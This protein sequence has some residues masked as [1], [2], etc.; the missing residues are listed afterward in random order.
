MLHGDHSLAGRPRRS[1][2]CI[3]HCD[4]ELLHARMSLTAS[5]FPSGVKR[6]SRSSYTAGSDD[7][8]PHSSG[9]STLPAEVAAADAAPAET[10]SDLHEH[11]GSRTFCRTGRLEG[12]GQEEHVT[13]G[14]HPP[15][16]S[17][18]THSCSQ[19]KGKQVFLVWGQTLASPFKRCIRADEQLCL[20]YTRTEADD[21]S[22]VMDLCPLSQL[23][24]A[25]LGTDMCRRVR[26]LTH[27]PPSWQGH[28][29]RGINCAS[30]LA[31]VSPAAPKWQKQ[32][33][34][35]SIWWSWV[36]PPPRHLRELSLESGILRWWRDLDQQAQLGHPCQR[37]PTPDSRWFSPVALLHY[38]HNQRGELGA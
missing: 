13:R 10:P 27:T 32:R 38:F 22:L 34:S 21:R 9:V 26:A 25:C 16:M 1:G 18:Y 31:S 17:S 12:W 6:A 8:H 29:K 23:S 37:Q 35:I 19:E 3:G 11:T 24:Q 33:P 20:N 28:S 4:D 14:A 5:F 36:P 2:T 15:W 30:F 7:Q